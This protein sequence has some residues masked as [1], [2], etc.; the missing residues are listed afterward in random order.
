MCIFDIDCHSLKRRK[1]AQFRLDLRQQ[2]RL[3]T[4]S[5]H[6]DLLGFIEFLRHII[7]IPIAIR[8]HLLQLPRGAFHLEAAVL[9]PLTDVELPRK[10]TN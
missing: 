8:F 10:L 7:R 4:L 1:R 5:D 3:A 9:V 2:V 6:L